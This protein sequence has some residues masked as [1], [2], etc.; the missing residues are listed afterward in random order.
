MRSIAALF[1]LLFTAIFIFGRVVAAPNS[2]PRAAGSADRVVDVELILAVDVS[3][4]IDP[5]ELRLQR[6]GYAN[7]IVSEE[8]LSALRE[9]HHRAISI[10]YFE[11]SSQNDQKLIVPWELIDSTERAHAVADAIVKAPLR[12]TSQTS[13]SAAINFAMQIFEKSPFKSV[14]RVI[15]IS[16]DG[17]NNHGDSL[18]TARNNAIARG[19]TINGLPIITGPKTSPTDVQ[20]LDLYYRDCVIGGPGAFIMPVSDSSRFKEAIRAKLLLEIS[21]EMPNAGFVPVQLHQSR[22]PCT[23]GE[24]RWR[25]RMRG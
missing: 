22:T 5:H 15:D 24:Q 25:E 20:D 19:V 7:A 2:L 14:K 17:P 23:A 13:I 4:S 8:F 1:A 9:G 11:W 18:A 21:L 10:A 12:R 6:E 16:G 3:H